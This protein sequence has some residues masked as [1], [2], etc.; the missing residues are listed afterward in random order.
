VAPPDA[1]VP[2]PEA[3]PAVPRAE[4]PPAPPA[5]A[6]SNPEPAPPHVTVVAVPASPALPMLV[7]VPKATAAA[8]ADAVPE[9]LQPVRVHI[10]RLEV[11][12]SLEEQARPR[13]EPEERPAAGLALADYLRGERETA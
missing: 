7:P 13:R 6:A 4:P 12:A 2:A 1:D 5:A 9:E 11:R 10:G 8:P 3:V